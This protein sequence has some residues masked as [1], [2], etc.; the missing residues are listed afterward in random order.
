MKV[1]TKV[2]KKIQIMLSETATE[3][4]WAR[5]AISKA[6]N[7]ALSKLVKQGLPGAEI[8]SQIQHIT[9]AGTLREFMAA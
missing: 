1:N 4:T 7:S 9:E 2:L 5:A 3:R 6:R 8:V